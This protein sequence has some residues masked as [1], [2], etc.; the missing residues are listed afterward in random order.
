MLLE[1]TENKE[2]F[3]AEKN[4]HYLGEVDLIL[5]GKTEVECALIF[6]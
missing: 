6:T 2:A 4:R 3:D 5:P 1:Q